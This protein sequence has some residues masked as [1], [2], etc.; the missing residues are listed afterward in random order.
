MSEFRAMLRQ[1]LA[2][3]LVE[4]QLRRTPGGL[5]TARAIAQTQLTGFIA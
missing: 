5:T 3:A 4:L 2:L 1:P